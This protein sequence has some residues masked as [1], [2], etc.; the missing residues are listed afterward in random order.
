M[1]TSKKLFLGLVGLTVLVAALGLSL[2]FTATDWALSGQL[3]MY[4]LSFVV[5]LVLFIALLGLGSIIYIIRT[6]RRL[7]IKLPLRLIVEFIYPFSLLLGR[8][9]RIDR[10]KIQNSFVEVNNALV[11]ASSGR[12]SAAKVLVLIPHCMQLADCSHKITVN[13]QN[14]KR[15]GRCQIAEML[16]LTEEFGVGLAVATGGGM[17]RRIIQELKPHAVVA[18][19]CERDLTSG[20]QETFPLPVFGVVNLRP[21][22]Y[23]FNTAVD[24]QRIRNALNYLING[25][26]SLLDYNSTTVEAA[27]SKGE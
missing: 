1:Q 22:G 10:Q 27:V 18:V 15:C 20:L 14:C 23:C 11:K 3:V 26:N 13:V 16:A 17:A 21:H 12:V 6:G 7:N 25:S 19:A 4:A 5:A 9:L 2:V 8:L 24:M